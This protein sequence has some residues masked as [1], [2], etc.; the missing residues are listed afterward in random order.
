MMT[1]WRSDT[2]T[3]RDG[4]KE[5]GQWGDDDDDRMIVKH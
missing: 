2:A 5:E 4:D 3:R 1:L